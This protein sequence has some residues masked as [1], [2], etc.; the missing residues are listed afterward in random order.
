[1]VEKSDRFTVLPAEFEAAADRLKQ[2]KDMDKRQGLLRELRQVIAEMD[3]L[4]QESLHK[5]QNLN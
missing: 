3:A 1:M 2:T 4:L 5:S